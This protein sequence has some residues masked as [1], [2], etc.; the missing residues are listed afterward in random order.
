MH[1]N[2]GLIV[3]GGTEVNISGSGKGSN[4][5]REFV[6]ESNLT[7]INSKNSNS[8]G[9]KSK[10]SSK[11][12]LLKRSN[13]SN[14]LNNQPPPTAQIHKEFKYNLRCKQGINGKSGKLNISRNVLNISSNNNFDHQNKF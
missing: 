13:S 8:L 2:Y 11:Y 6:T 7:I 14:G 5:L 9:S 12:S 4:E 10:N 1:N 3:T